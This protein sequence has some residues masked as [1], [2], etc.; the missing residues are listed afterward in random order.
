MTERAG[1]QRVGFDPIYDYVLREW[2]EGW[3]TPE[4]TNTAN[5]LLD[6]IEAAEL[7][8][9]TREAHEEYLAAYVLQEIRYGHGT[10]TDV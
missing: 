7:V 9:I 2:F 1:D 8:V 5:E 6:A 3:D 10:V 4:A